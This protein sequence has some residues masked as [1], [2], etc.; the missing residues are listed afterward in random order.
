MADSPPRA[1]HVD[2]F[3]PM[4][5]GLVVVLVPEPAEIDPALAYYADYSQSREEL[6]RAF[7]HLERAW[8]WQPVTVHTVEAVLDALVAEARAAGTSLPVILNLCDGD[9]GNTVPGVEVIDA[10]EARG[11]AYTGAD[12]PFYRLTTSKLPMKAAFD[13]GAV[14][15][16]PWQAWDPTAHA[17]DV[18]ATIGA[19]A[20]VKPAVSAGS[21]GVTTASVVHTAEALAAQVAALHAGYH[22]WDLLSGGVL[23]ERYVSGRE[24]TVLLVG[25]AADAERLLVYT[26]AERVFHASLRPEER[27]LSYDRLWEVYERETPMPNGDFF[28]EYAPV[29]GALADEI[30]R[31]S[32]L[33]YEA[34]GGRGYGRVDLRQC[35][36]TGELFVLEVN[37]QCA[38]SEDENYTS[39]GAILRFSGASFASLVARLLDDAVRR[40]PVKARRKR[41][42]VA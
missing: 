38:L 22:G 33:A 23:V 19:P 12:A 28:W 30:V 7:A 36:T 21:M 2:T 25:D 8:R 3:A 32:L 40:V 1:P 17:T 5:A 34:V 39:V 29:T 27:F 16:A 6:T 37:A 14:P 13:A 31:V 9:E 11:F 15:T 4:T 24:F 20:I 26:P 10:L 41:R 35:S 42:A 18:L